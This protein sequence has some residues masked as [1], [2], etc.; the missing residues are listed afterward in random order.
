MGSFPSLTRSDTTRGVRPT[1]QQLESF[2][3]VARTLSFRRAAEE[4]FTAQSALSAQ[5]KRLEELLGVRLFERDRRRTRLTE[6]GERARGMALQVLEDLDRLVDAMRADRDPLA[7]TLRLGVI[8]TIAP[9]LV[10]RLAAVLRERHPGAELLVQEDPTTRLA[11]RLLSGDLDAVVLDID[12][13]LPNLRSE[14]VYEESLVLACPP[15]HPLAERES[16]TL[17][18]VAEHELLLLEQ[19]HCLSD[20]IRSFCQGPRGQAF[21]DFRATSLLTLV[22]MVAAGVGATLLPEFAARDFTH[23]PGLSL[24]PFADPAPARRV[25]LAWRPSDARERAFETLAALID[26]AADE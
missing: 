15:D 1:I 7:G 14:V 21:G 26:V 9:F 20:R 11:A 19:E 13:E 23:L 24:V 8:P 16:V 6:D 18:D 22:H 12:V 5:V 3:A 10:P 25:G 4:S 17:D 2:L